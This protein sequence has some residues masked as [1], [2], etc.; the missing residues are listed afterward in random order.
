MKD[1]PDAQAHTR[2][3]PGHPPAPLRGHAHPPGGPAGAQK[4]GPGRHVADMHISTSV[5]APRTWGFAC[6]NTRRSLRIG[7]QHYQSLVCAITRGGR[8]D[9]GAPVHDIRY[10]RSGVPARRRDLA[11][12][13]SCP[14]GPWAATSDNALTTFPE[15]SYG[16][17][18][19]VSGDRDES[20]KAPRGPPPRDTSQPSLHTSH[21]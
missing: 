6:L 15:S 10:V 4:G 13:R 2:D 7:D 8:D 9:I 14:V 11:P 18:R 20:L 21:R 1:R 19:R 17:C 5:R 3:L 12:A 16:L